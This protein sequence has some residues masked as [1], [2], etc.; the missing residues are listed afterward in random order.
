[1]RASD[2][3]DAFGRSEFSGRYFYNTFKGVNP[4]GV[5]NAGIIWSTGPKWAAL[6]RFV[7]RQL[8]DFG[9]SGSGKISMKTLVMEEV[10][11]LIE[12]F[13]KADG[14][15]LKTVH[16]FNAASFNVILKITTGQKFQH[17]DP[18]LLELVHNFG[19]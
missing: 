13:R 7:L 1:M 4:G 8:R 5:H 17:D 18:Q 15:P 6:R 9:G 11:E 3:R 10:D 14:K 19:E 12:N 16:T 2:I